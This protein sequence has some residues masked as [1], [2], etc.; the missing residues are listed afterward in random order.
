MVQ[1]PI[2]IAG[3]FLPIRSLSPACALVLLASLCSPGAPLS[4]AEGS[5]NAPVKT[6]FFSRSSKPSEKTAPNDPPPASKKAAS[7]TPAGGASQGAANSPS[8]R[9]APSTQDS[10]AA[11][12]GVSKKPTDPKTEDELFVTAR[13]KAL[14]DPGIGE[15]RSKADKAKD[16]ESGVSATRAYLKSLYS[17][18]RDLE[19]ALKERIDLTE[20]AALQGLAKTP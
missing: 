17:K 15:L 19:P 12:R 2:R 4:A 13:L 6:G 9:T 5:P 16:K 7:G 11:R 20:A 1:H 14:E 3:S 18:M 8:S 10:K